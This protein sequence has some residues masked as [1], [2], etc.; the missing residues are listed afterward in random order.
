MSGATGLLR[1]RQNVLA[2]FIITFQSAL[3]NC[4]IDYPADLTQALEQG[5]GRGHLD[6]LL[7]PYTDL[8]RL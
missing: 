4:E 5:G 1:P 6:S 2:N 7:S 8:R 3:Q